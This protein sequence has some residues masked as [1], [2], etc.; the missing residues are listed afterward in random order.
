M[1]LALIRDQRADAAHL[2]AGDDD[3][4]DTQRAALHQHGR[5]RTAAA[6]ELGF[7]HGAFGRT[8]GVGLEVEDFGLQRDHLEQL[9]EIG[10]VL[11]GDLDIDDSPPIDSTWTSYCSSSVRTRSGLASGLSI[12]LIATIIGTFAALA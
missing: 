11:G 1:V 3:V 10:L 7:D 5:D 4:A 2:G 8:L 9:V 6:I 12:L